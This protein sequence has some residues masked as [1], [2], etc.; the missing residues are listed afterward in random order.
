MDITAAAS[1]SIPGTCRWLYS[2]LST[3]VSASTPIP[4]PVIKR[5]IE[6]TIAA[7]HSI[8]SCPYG[9]SLSGCLDDS[10]IPITTIIVLNT[11]DAEWI[12]SLI[13]AFEC[14]N[15]PAN[16]FINDKRMFTT[17]VTK[18]TWFATFWKS[19]CFIFVTSKKYLM[20]LTIGGC[21][22]LTRK[23]V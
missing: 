3:S 5:T 16:S 8:R 10:L 15:T 23:K 9:C 12:L 14:A 7:T 11:S 20:A 17:I 21:C 6:R 13:I 18:D 1:A 22:G 2:P 4:R 19:F